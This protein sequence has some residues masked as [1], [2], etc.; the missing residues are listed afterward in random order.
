MRQEARAASVGEVDVH[1]PDYMEEVVAT[2]SHLA[3]ASTHVNQRSGVSVRLVGQQRRGARR[4]RPAARPA[5]RRA[6]VVPRICDLE[7]LAASSGGKIEIESLEEGRDGLILENLVKGAV[8]TVFK[9]RVSPDQVREVIAAFEEGVVAHTGED[10]PSTDVA[11]LVET[12]PAL[13]RSSPSSPAATSRRRRSPRRSS[14]CSRACTCRSASTRTRRAGGPPTAAAAE[15]VASPADGGGLTRF[16][17][18][19]DEARE[20]RH[21]AAGHAAPVDQLPGQRG[22]LRDH[23]QHRRRLL[24]LPRRPAAPADPLPLQQR[25]ARRRRPLPLR[26]RRR[27]R[28]LL[29]AD[30]AADAC[31]P[32]RLPLPARARLHG[33]RLAP[34]RRSRWRRRTSCRSARR[35]RS[36]GR[37]SPTTARRPPACRCS[38]RSSSASGTPWTTPPT[39]SATSRSA[40]SRWWPTR[41]SSTTRT[42]YRERRNHFAYFACSAPLAGFDTQREAFLGPYR[43]WDRPLVVERGR[44]ADSIAHGWPPCGSHHVDLELGPGERREVVF[45]LGYAENPAD[46]KFDP[47]GSDTLDKR[48]VTP[49]HRALPP[50]RRRSTSRSRARRALGRVAV[51]AA[52]RHAEPARRPDGQHLERLPVHGHLQPVPLGVPVRVG[53]R[54]RHGVPRLE[55][56]PARLRAHGAGAGTGADPRHRRHPAARRAAPTT[57]TSR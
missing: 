9:E 52:D 41:A 11:R 34:R 53:H 50:P 32:R 49:G 8:L 46:A 33:H 19:D 16:G 25:P 24:V 3:R 44:S 39:S 18:F 55:P 36:G 1:V 54:A 43:G 6:V 47:P 30:L 10:V 51:D 7:A 42:E 29:D 23:L 4:Q 37:R 22:V 15:A 26:P 2:F 13:R 5:R 56:G 38:A 35:S 40:R 20:V 17:H 12:V 27:D 45:V 48:R 28:G 21:H 57:S 31:G 14:S